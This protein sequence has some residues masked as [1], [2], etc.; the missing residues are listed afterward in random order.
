MNSEINKI[1]E[2]K[3]R[4]AWQGVISRDVLSFSF[5]SSLVILGI[6]ASG[7]F[8]A[9]TLNFTSNGQPAQAN[10]SVVGI[11]ILVVG[12]LISAISYFA[13]RVKEYA[14]TKKRVIIKSGLIGTDFKSIYY[15]QMKNVIV[16]VGLIGKIF[17]VGTLQID[18]GKTH[19]YST[20]GRRGGR[21]SHGT[22]RTRTVYDNL[23]HITKPYEVYKH[24]QSSLSGRKESLYSGRADRESN[25]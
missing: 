8:L 14:I 17:R 12:V 9:G 23:K 21:Y 11:G 7:F 13:D 1:L 6:I 20:G 10:G 16:N 4:I 3:E 25:S 5:F 15:D 19:T 24:L 2:P 22:V 18:T